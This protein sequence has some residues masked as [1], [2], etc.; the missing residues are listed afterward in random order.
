MLEWVRRY[1][2]SLPHATESVQWGDALVFKVAG[3]MFA[4]ASLEPRTHWLSFKS[5]PEEFAEWIE[6]PGVI[7]APYLARANWVALEH[8][9]ALT[10]AELKRSLRKSYDLVCAK[11]PKKVRTELSGTTSQ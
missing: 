2:L 10:A 9:D 1:C 4:V 5:A 3:K 11:L 8:E 6:R 7:P